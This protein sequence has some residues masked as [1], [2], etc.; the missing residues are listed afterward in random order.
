MTMNKTPEEAAS[1]I[2]L[3]Q[4]KLGSDN[5]LSLEKSLIYSQQLKVSKVGFG[6]LIVTLR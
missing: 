3:E 5:Q 2:L 6:N 1:I 4:T